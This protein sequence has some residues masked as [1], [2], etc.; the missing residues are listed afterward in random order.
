MNSI[1]GVKLNRYGVPVSQGL[2]G[3]PRATRRAS[4]GGKWTAQE[5]VQLKEIVQ[6]HGA[7]CW[8][9]VHNSAV[10]YL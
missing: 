9:K 5:D 1:D 8:K 4:V 10:P 7:K 6:M 3:K 2:M